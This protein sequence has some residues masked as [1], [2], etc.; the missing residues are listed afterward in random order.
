MLDYP[1]LAAVA[2]V[3][4]EGS[5][6]RAAAALAITPS[7]VSQ[8]VRGLEERL[9]AILIVRGQPCEATELG[10]S[11]CAHLDQVRLL[12]HDLA[13]ALGSTAAGAGDRLTLPVAVNADSLATW[14]PAAA[15]AFGRVADVSLDLTL[16]D[17]AHTANRLRAG[18]VMAAVT[19]EREPVQGC[20]TLSLGALRYAA[21]ASP[22][23]VA[24][25]FARGITPQALEQAPC[26]RF[27]RRDFLQARWARAALGVE[28]VGPVHWVP[29]THG[30]LDMTLVGLGWGMH[31]CAMVEDRIAAGHLI[32]LAPAHRVD[33][34]LY[35]TVTRLHAAALN[36]L[37]QAVS[38]AAGEV[39]GR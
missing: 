18:E 3:V 38:T 37:T 4:R 9:G 11:L 1:A 36:Q 25:Y 2:A 12:E 29:S 33:V 13:P 24:R 14:F 31:P 28:R 8:R 34:P 7:A 19:A 17:E 15:A 35:W 16:D 23:F 6:E 5:F 39:L 30:F 10:R 32:E 27:D 26:L 22:E 21:C 20:R